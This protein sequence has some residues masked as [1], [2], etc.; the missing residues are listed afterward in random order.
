MI[1]ADIDIDV[2]DRDLILQHIE[3]I[4]A[5]IIKS[6]ESKKH[7]SGVYCQ[8]IPRNPFDGRAS[9]DYKVAEERGYFKLDLLNNTMYRKVKDLDHMDK[10]LEIEPSWELLEHKAVVD[11]LIHINGYSHIT[12]MYK[13][14]SIMELAMCIAIIRPGKAYLYGKPLNEVAKEIWKPTKEYYFKKSHAISYAMAITVQ[15][16][17]LMGV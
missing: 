8:K 1:K 11:T 13:P 4:P 12:K 15:M 16:N 2:P 17:L 14:K 9:I 7:A 5:S 6:G 10:L 3:H